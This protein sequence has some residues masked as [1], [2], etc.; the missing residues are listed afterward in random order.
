LGAR[1]E[2]YFRGTATQASYFTGRFSV[3]PHSPIPDCRRQP[4]DLVFS[5]IMALEVAVVAVV[6][7][8][9]AV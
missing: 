6:V 1:E 5:E 8:A 2:N 9:A 3:Y 4:L 7:V